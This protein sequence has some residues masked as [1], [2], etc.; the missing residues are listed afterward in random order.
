MKK[1]VEVSA[2][3]GKRNGTN[4]SA[5]GRYVC[6]ATVNGK[7]VVGGEIEVEVK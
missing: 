2:K 3:L 5:A 7:E 6:V 4:V 1:R